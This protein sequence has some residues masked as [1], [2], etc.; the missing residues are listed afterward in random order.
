MGGSKTDYNRI[1]G[2]SLTFPVAKAKK[3]KNQL[4][5]LHCVQKEDAIS[6][7]AKWFLALR[8]ENKLSLGIVT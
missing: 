1:V 3:E 6:G 2:I 5:D 8:T 4:Y 7:E